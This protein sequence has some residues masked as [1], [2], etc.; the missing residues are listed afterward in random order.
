MTED[1]QRVREKILSAVNGNVSFKYPGS[2][3]DKH[4][5]LTERVVVESVNAS[6]TVPYWDVVDLIEFK[7]L[8]EPMWLRI[9]YY[10]K[11]GEKLIW[12]SHTT[13]TEPISIGKK[14]LVSAGKEKKWFRDLLESVMEELD[15]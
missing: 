3:G 7:D 13:I 15:K 12:G 4:G 11:P 2:E 10:R 14:I 8:K 6:G 5:V 9:G 1:T